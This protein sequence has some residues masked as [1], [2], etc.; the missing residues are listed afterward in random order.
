MVFLL[1]MTLSNI[2]VLSNVVMF[3][4][5]MT[6]SNIVVCSVSIGDDPF[7]HC[8]AFQCCGISIGNE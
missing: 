5:V 3:L 7:Q 6:L 8:G 2:V 1:V 4:L